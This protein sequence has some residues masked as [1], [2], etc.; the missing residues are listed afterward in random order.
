M[1]HSTPHT[2]PIKPT[3]LLRTRQHIVV[4]ELGRVGRAAEHVEHLLRHNGAAG[5]VDRRQQHGRGG[6]AL[7]DQYLCKRKVKNKNEK[8]RV[9]IGGH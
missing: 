5:E 6:E 8:M 1:P 9:K 2:K 3:T 7:R 4:I